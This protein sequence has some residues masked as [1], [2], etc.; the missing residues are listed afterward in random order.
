MLNL[1]SNFSFITLFLSLA[2]SPLFITYAQ[3]ATF[4]DVSEFKQA[5][6]TAQEKEGIQVAI[7][8]DP[9]S[10][11]YR[12]QII[13]FGKTSEKLFAYQALEKTGLQI[14]YHPSYN[15]PETGFFLIGLNGISN[16]KSVGWSFSQWH[17]EKQEWY[18]DTFECELDGKPDTCFFA[19]GD[20][21]LEDGS[22]I[23]L[24]FTGLDESD[25]PKHR[26]VDLKQ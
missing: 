12:I 9:I 19:L 10:K 22:I 2:L 18:N 6:Q 4:N 1:K 13:D 20:C 3:Q 5:F 24:S 14:M 25:L 17:N 15:N 16:Q 8:I 23:G 26:P 11:P 21:P 7:V